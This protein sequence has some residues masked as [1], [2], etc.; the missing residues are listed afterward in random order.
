MGWIKDNH[1]TVTRKVNNHARTLPAKVDIRQKM[2]GEIAAAHV[3]DAF[4][5]AGKMHREVWRAAA[6]YTAIDQR[7]YKDQRLAYVADNRRVLRAIDLQRFNVFDL[8]AYGS[9][10][11][12]ALIIAARRRVAPGERL[13]FALTDGSTLNLKMGGLPIAIREL[14]GFGAKVDGALRLQDEVF[15]RCLLGLANRLRCRLLLRWEARG[16]TAAMVRY[17]GVVL[18]GLP[19]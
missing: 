15:D 5:G 12:Q 10:W 9:P 4:A 6:S 3:L 16:K 8:D 1:L 17:L 14:A 13:A 19:A 18:E 7:W 11:E 2:L